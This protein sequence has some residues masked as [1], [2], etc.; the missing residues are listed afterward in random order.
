M[1]TAPDNGQV[2]YD[3]LPAIYREKDNGDLQAYLAAYGELFDAIERT[4]D[5]KLADNFPDTPDEGIICQDWLLPYFAKLLDA[6]LVSPHAAGRR[7]EISHAVSWRQ[8]KGSTSVVEDIA[9]S[10]G[11]M[12][13]EVQ[14]GWQRVATTARIGMPLLPAVNF[15]VSPAPDME[16]PSEAARHPGLLAATVDLRYV[17][18]VIK[19]QTGCGEAKVQGNPHGVPCFPGGYD[20]AS[21]RTVDLRTPSWSQGHHHP[22][23]ILL[24]APPAPGFFSEVRHEIHWKDRAKPEFA[25]LIEIID[26]EKR[27]LVRNISGQPIHFIGQVKLLKAKDYTLEGFSFGTTISCKLG[28]LFLK[29]VAA[30]KVVAQYDGPLA[31]SLSAKGCLFRDVTTATGLMR[32]EY[33]T[34]LRKTIAEWIEASDCIFL[35]ILQKDH[36]HAVPPLSGCI[37]YS[38]LPVMPLGVVSLFHCTTDKPIFFQD[39]YGEYACAVLHPANLDSIKHGAEDGGEMGCYH[40]RRYVLRGEAIIDKLTDFLPVGL[41]A[42]LVPDMNLVCA[43][44][45]AET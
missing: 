23:R 27:Y 20:D 8:R 39:D 21:R 22:K 5:Q 26:S 44:P 35:G 16:I 28:R 37:R 42:V 7:D 41:E 34:V 1:S 38:R 6:R 2:L 13:V 40:D 3:L 14:E 31:P 19:Q 11:G 25:K 29:D 43:P 18:R 10:V 45:I 9:E 32:L 30:P 36:L 24:Y 15:G 4:L 12:E 17:S 33:C